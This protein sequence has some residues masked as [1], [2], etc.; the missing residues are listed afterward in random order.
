MTIIKPRLPK[1]MRDFSSDVMQKRNFI[2]KNI[3]KVFES[4]GFSQIETPSIE[5]MET[6][7]GKYG[8][9]GD[10]LIFKILNSGDFC[11]IKRLGN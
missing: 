8:E 4:Y 11:R 6:L 10:R 5:N 9:E 3:R 2:F 1:G 7:S